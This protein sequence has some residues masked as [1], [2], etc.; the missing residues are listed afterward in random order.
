MSRI[1]WGSGSSQPRGGDRTGHFQQQQQPSFSHNS[2]S[3]NRIPWYETIKTDRSAQERP[4]WNLTSYGHQR[5][6]ENDV[7]GDISP[8]EVRFANML[9]IQNGNASIHSLK[10]E[11]RRANRQRVD[12]FQGLTRRRQPPSLEGHPVKAPMDS[13][14]N[15][16]WLRQNGFGGMNNSSMSSGFTGNATPIQPFGGMGG[17]GVS[18]SGGFG[19]VFGQTG[20][21]AGFGTAGASQLPT[22][23]SFEHASQ[24]GTQP[25]PFGSG[26]SSQTIYSS[27]G[28]G[29]QQVPSMPQ[30]QQLN[31]TMQPSTTEMTMSSGH[32][33]TLTVPQGSVMGSE[34]AVSEEDAAK[35]MQS[36]FERGKIPS[37]PPPHHVC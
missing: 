20:A 32:T 14:Q 17:A 37:V 33:D 3:N 16:I 24:M 15:L 21:S 13:I 27:A 22:S 1:Q 25:A 6:K 30:Q 36:H 9:S 7:C 26:P 29:Q 23:S 18:G 35:W 12:V 19:S 2:S 4:L 5:E 8:E 11:F 28:W 31:G 34:P 10:D